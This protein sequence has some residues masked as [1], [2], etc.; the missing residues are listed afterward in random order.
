MAPLPPPVQELFLALSPAFSQPTAWRLLWL[1]A[2]AVVASGRRT[3]CHILAWLR[4]LAR[5]RHTAFHRVFSR[6]R[7]GWQ[8]PR[9]LAAAVLARLPPGEPVV[10]LVDDTTTEHPGRRVWGKDKHRD[11]VR[12]SRSAWKWLWGHRWVVLAVSVAVPGA[13]R[14]RALPV[15]SALYRS[16]GLNRR[17]GR[18]HR[19]VIQIA[20]PLV[21]LLLRWFPGRRFVLVADGGYGSHELARLGQRYR[22]RLTVVSKFYPGAN[23]FGPPPP[24]PGSGRPREKGDRLPR[25]REVVAARPGHPAEVAWYGGAR[26][27]VGLVGGTGL[28]HHKGAGLVTVRWVHVEDRQGAHRP[29]Y[30][31]STDPRMPLR[32]I[33]ELYTR[34]WSI[35][36]TFQEAR[37][38]LG[39]GTTRVRCRRSV[40]RAEPWLLG[41][42][43]LVCLVHLRAGR[44]GPVARWPRYQK[45]EPTFADALAGARRALWGEMI[46][47]GPLFAPGAEKLSP[48]ARELLI[49]T[50]SMAA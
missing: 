2:G 33:V 47:A 22:G 21:R 31:F 38:K 26:R 29:E 8:A 12:S 7:W 20:I 1:T 41:V 50:L 35:E 27:R 28:W 4:G 39:F 6:A 19:T 14:R 9:R 3:T 49:E 10:L 46:L 48:Q 16:P 36:V 25:P 15:L 30:F 43:T 24:Y 11:A 37:A 44:A 18:R 32:R 23:L 42:F 45:V 13:S 34:R 5:G 40:Q 17:E